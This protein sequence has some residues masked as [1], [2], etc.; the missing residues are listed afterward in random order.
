MRS[1]T[2]AVLAG[3]CGLWLALTGIGG[4]DQAES[5]KQAQMS[6]ALEIISEQCLTGEGVTESERA[7]ACKLVRSV[8]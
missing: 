5:A 3:M 4:R 6:A 8:K 2:V 7:E 1:F